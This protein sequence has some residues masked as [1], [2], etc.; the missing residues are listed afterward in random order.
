LRMPETTTATGS[1]PPPTAKTPKKK[2]GKNRP[3]SPFLASAPRAMHLE[4]MG[5]DTPG[6]GT[7]LPASTFGK[8][9]SSSNKQFAKLASPEFRSMSKQRPDNKMAA[10]PG[11]GAHSPNKAAT[12]DF[13]RRTNSAPHMKAK[14]DR[15]AHGSVAEVD[16]NTGTVGPG[17]YEYQIY[18]SVQ[19]TTEN[20]VKLM[21]RQNPGFG[22][23]SASHKLPHEQDVEDDKE[24]PGP[25]KYETNTSRINQ[26]SGHSSSFKLP[27][28][29]PKKI[30]SRFG[31][32]IS[33]KGGSS[34]R[35]GSA[36]PAKGTGSKRGG[37]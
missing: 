7:Y 11:P 13:K 9:A 6:P 17:E 24:L 28:A 15:F 37:K 3:P 27:T 33:S 36:P 16:P 12:S 29:Q 22:T 4:I 21:S 31:D 14:G 35:G 1:A 19:Q 25:G 26:A 2:G 5:E 20:K 34:K 23:A 30:A 10:Y 8:Y 32:V 18:K